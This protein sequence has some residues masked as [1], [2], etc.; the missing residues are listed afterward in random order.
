MSDRLVE[1]KAEWADVNVNELPILDI[2][3]L[4][5]EV[6]RLKAANADA[7]TKNDLLRLS[8]RS[9]TQFAEGVER[10]AV[11]AEGWF[12]RIGSESELL[13]AAIRAEIK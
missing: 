2:D 4:I 13:A 6:E 7:K 3:W 11:I 5:A 8:A 1:I 12:D 10:A 9:S